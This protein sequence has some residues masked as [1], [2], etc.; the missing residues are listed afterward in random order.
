MI[1][2]ITACTLLVVLLG[3]ILFATP[4]NRQKQVLESC[5]ALA[6]GDNAAAG[7]AGDSSAIK[8]T[9]MYITG[10]DGAKIKATY[11][12]PG[13][14]GP[15]VILLH[16]CND[17][18]DRKSWVPLATALAHRGIHVMTYDFRGHGET[19]AGGGAENPPGD[20]DAALATLLA[21]P[22]VD[23]QHIGA[24]GASCGAAYAYLLTARYGRMKALMLLSGQLGDKGLEYLSQHN[25][26]AVFDAA[27]SEEDTNGQVINKTV[28]ASKNPASVATLV[29]NGG[30]GVPMFKASPD[31][32][33]TVVAWFEKVLKN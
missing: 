12:S 6:S 29:P 2:K 9:D 3:C 17:N 14:P 13:K 5:L 16:Q 22:G 21:Q 28:A 7:S 25:E 4:V 10:A 24:G 20:A 8:I 1:I 33:P 11:Y 32:L 26:L 31:L 15:A 19:P 30:H 27:S 18:F 23:A